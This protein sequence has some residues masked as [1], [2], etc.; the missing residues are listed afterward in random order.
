MNQPPQQPASMPP[1]G[2]MLC[3][4]VYAAGLAFNRLYRGLLERFGLTYPQ[5]LVLVALREKDGRRV[6]ELGETLFLES[7]TLT[8]L[9]K[10][11]EQAGLISRHRDSRD[12]RVVRVS[13]TAKGAELVAGMGC[14]APQVAGATGMDIG[15]IP[16]LTAKLN[17]LGSALR[18]Q[19]QG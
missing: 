2:A 6:N 11:M 14:V 19:A 5:F 8:P 13:L 9:L 10:R 4:S 16:A 18:Q 15:D 1:L 3:F 17:A 7:N 12:E